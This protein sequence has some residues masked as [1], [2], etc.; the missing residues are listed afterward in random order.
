MLGIYIVLLSYVYCYIVGYDFK[1]V[2]NL[3][4]FVVKVGSHPLFFLQHYKQQGSC[5]PLG[6]KVHSPFPIQQ[7]C[8]PDPSC[9]PTHQLG[10]FIALPT[11]QRWSRSQSHC[12]Q[13]SIPLHPSQGT[14]FEAGSEAL[15]REFRDELKKYQRPL[16][17]IVSLDIVALEGEGQMGPSVNC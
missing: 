16:N 8:P 13:L 5:I 10:S 11:N 1:S 14:L 17:P 6:R 4:S 15:S 7:A 12:H 9:N 2:N 3:V